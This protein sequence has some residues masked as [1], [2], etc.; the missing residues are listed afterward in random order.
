[1]AGLG[2]RS[3]SAGPIVTLPFEHT[4]TLLW[5]SPQSSNVVPLEITSAQHRFLSTH[6]HSSY[7]PQCAFPT[8]TIYHCLQGVHHRWDGE[9]AVDYILITRVHSFLDSTVVSYPARQVA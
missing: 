6:L 1:M 3:T 4:Q 7:I 5:A 2:K 8:R 9:Q